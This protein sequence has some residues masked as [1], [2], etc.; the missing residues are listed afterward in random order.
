MKLVKVVSYVPGK[1]MRALVQ[2]ERVFHPADLTPFGDWSC[3][4]ESV[5]DVEEPTAAMLVALAD[6]LL[7]KGDKA[8]AEKAARA[9]IKMSLGDRET[10]LGLFVLLYKADMVELAKKAVAAMDAAALS[11]IDDFVEDIRAD[12]LSHLEP[13]KQGIP[14]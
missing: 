3:L 1:E 10:L 5:S 13:L 9:A 8:S 2:E 14:A 12:V 11:Q 4:L 7:A 6:R